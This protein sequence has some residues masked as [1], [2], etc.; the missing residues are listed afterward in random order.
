MSAET[1]SDPVAR[2]ILD[3]RSS[4]EDWVEVEDAAEPHETPQNEG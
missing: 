2:E 4:D 3:G 1:L